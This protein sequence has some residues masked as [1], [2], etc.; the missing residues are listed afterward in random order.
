MSGFDPVPRL[1]FRISG[2]GLGI[3]V[4]GFGFRMSGFDPVPGFGLR[5]IPVGHPHSTA[6]QGILPQVNW[7]SVSSQMPIV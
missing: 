6:G 5:T 4:S 2:L 1:G 7:L 3:Q